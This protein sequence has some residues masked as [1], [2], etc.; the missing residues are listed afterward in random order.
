MIEIR[1]NIRVILRN[2]NSLNLFINEKDLEVG[3]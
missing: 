3:L 2:I 1:L